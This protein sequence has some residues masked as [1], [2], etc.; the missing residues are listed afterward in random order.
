M[1]LARYGQNN[2][3]DA[4]VGSTVSHFVD[5]IC[6]AEPQEILKNIASIFIKIFKVY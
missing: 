4:T 5:N 3:N 1:C 2:I 6:K